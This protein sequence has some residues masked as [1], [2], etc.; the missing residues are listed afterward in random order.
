MPRLLVRV[1]VVLPVAPL[2]AMRVDV[3]C[4]R[5]PTRVPLRLKMNV[6]CSMIFFEMMR[7]LTRKRQPR[8]IRVLRKPHPR[9]RMLVFLRLLPL[10]WSC[11]SLTCTQKMDYLGLRWVF[12]FS[13]I[14][15]GSYRLEAR[16]FDLF[17]ECQEA[18]ALSA[19]LCV[20]LWRPPFFFMVVGLPDGV[21]FAI[22]VAGLVDQFCEPRLDPE[23]FYLT[24]TARMTNSGGDMFC[25]YRASRLGY[26]A[27][28]SSGIAFL[29]SS[30]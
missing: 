12:C 15:D 3:E 14:F 5:Y 8:G 9:R 2:V 18:Y 4:L 21:T 26:Y 7:V 17:S 28:S 23:E 13:C 6:P 20:G 16:Y 25:S 1:G 22:K 24:V 29:T 19:G 27:F 30:C 11:W 10:L